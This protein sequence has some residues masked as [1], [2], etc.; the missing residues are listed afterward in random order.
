[1]KEVKKE[2]VNVKKGREGR[3][4]RGNKLK[5]ERQKDDGEIDN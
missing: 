3:K 2:L 1:L 5:E 4:K